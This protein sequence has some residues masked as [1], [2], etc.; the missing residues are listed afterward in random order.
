MNTDTIRKVIGFFVFMITAV[1][2]FMTVQSNVSFWDC[3]EFIASSSLL[4]V[5][6]PP[7]TPFFLILGRFFS[8]LPFGD[9]V[10]F[11]VNSI[12]V[13]SSAFTVLFLYLVAVKVI[14]NF[15][16]SDTS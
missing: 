7:G 16:K 15:R 11:R 9:N 1:V 10:A 12:S 3:G 6:H 8:M 4:Q 14:E 5:P 2:Y 13:V